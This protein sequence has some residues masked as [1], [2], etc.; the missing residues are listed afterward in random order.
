[1]ALTFKKR[2]DLDKV[3]DELAALPPQVEF[4]DPD[5]IE[6]TSDKKIKSVRVNIQTKALLIPVDG[7]SQTVY[8]DKPG[9]K[10]VYFKLKSG[11]KIGEE[12][13]IVRAALIHGGFVKI[14]PLRCPVP[15]TLNL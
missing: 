9:D 3:L 6:K 8:F 15:G 1:M 4:T 5:K 2:D 12:K 7:S 10:I 14:H 13:L 11:M